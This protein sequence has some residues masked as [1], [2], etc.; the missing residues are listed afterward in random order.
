[1]KAIYIFRYMQTKIILYWQI[2]LTRNT[3]GSSSGCK[4]VTRGG[5]SNPKG[6]QAQEKVIT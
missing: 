4:Q 5:N 1:M 6:K 3:K 2:H